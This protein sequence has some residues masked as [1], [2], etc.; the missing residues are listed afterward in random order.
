MEQPKL[1]YT[2]H[3]DTKASFAQTFHHKVN[4]GLIKC[5][6]CHDAHGTSQAKNLKTTADRN[7]ICTKCHTENAGPFAFEHPPV[8]TEGCVSCH[9]PHGSPNPRLL[10]V[11]NVNT[12]CIS[13]HSN[14]NSSAFPH[15]ATLPSGPVHNQNAAYV[16]CTTCHT[17]IHGS[18]ASDVY[19]K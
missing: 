17:Q 2:C 13:C 6:D 14:T 12:L 18:N 16:S 11:A 8:K 7:E 1:C 4:E 15:A 19:F 10:N 3:S 5:S 9:T